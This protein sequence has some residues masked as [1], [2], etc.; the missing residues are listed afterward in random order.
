M[1]C[2][3][4]IRRYNRFVGEKNIDYNFLCTYTL[5]KLHHTAVKYASNKYGIIFQ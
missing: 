5:S 4:I 1:T 3:Y 2:K